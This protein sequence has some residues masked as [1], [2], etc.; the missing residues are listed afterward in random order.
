MVY[1][2]C[3]LGDTTP[4]RPRPRYPLHP[5]YPPLRGRWYL[6]GQMATICSPC[7]APPTGLLQRLRCRGYAARAM[8]H[9]L[10]CC[11]AHTDRHAP[12][13]ALATQIGVLQLLHWPHRSACPK[14][15][16]GHAD[17]YAPTAAL[18]TQIS[19]PQVLHWPHRTA[20]SNCC[21]GH[22]DQ[23]APTAALATRISM[24]DMHCCSTLKRWSAHNAVAF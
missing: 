23:H 21:T 15:C 16:T 3:C 14:C 22:T 11:T 17:H 13:A 8:V 12:T 5:R 2:N 7:P 18:A 4:G 20:C 19:M 6:R 10:H 9:M 1:C 24:L